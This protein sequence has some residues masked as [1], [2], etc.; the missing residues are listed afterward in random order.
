MGDW[1]H[2]PWNAHTPAGAV[3]PDPKMIPLPRTMDA[4]VMRALNYA[5][6]I[7]GRGQDY[8]FGGG[9]GGWNYG[10]PFDCSGFVSAILHFGLGV[11]GFPQSTYGLIPGHNGL[12]GGPGR[13]V[14]GYTR[15]TGDPHQSHTFISING[16][17]FESGGQRPEPNGAGRTSRSTAGFTPWHPPGFDR[18]G[19]VGRDFARP[20]FRDVI[21]VLAR[22]GEA[23]VTPE[24]MAAGAGGMV[25]NFPNYVGDKRELQR[26][27]VDALADYE[28]RNG[29]TG[30]TPPDE[31]TIPR[32]HPAHPPR[33]GRV[34]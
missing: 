17:Q 32:G 1:E 15:N 33:A 30:A 5:N 21:P 23:I 14:T 26:T 11:L 7:A 2:W 3:G 6:G 18:G 24:Q 19:V 12:L 27:I 34:R 10:G 20:S 8:V 9:H 25:F 16:Q 29:R 13:F 22:R 4:R 28:K 31:R